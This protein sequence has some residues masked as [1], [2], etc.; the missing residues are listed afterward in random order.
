MS[1]T[2]EGVPN[3]GAPNLNCMSLIEIGEFAIRH[4]DGAAA[5]LIF[6]NATPGQ[7]NA[8]ATLAVYAV[9]LHQAMTERLA[10]HIADALALERTCERIYRN[11]PTWVRW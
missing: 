2:D 7:V 9:F 8:V 4:K 1:D 10:G 5:D 6:P 11:L 3:L